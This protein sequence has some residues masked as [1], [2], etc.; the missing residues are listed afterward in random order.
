MIK[1]ITARELHLLLH[2]NLRSRPDIGLRNA[3]ADRVLEPANP[4]EP[5]AVQPPRRW[6]VL[7]CVLS[8]L[9]IGLFVYFNALATGQDRIEPEQLDRFEL[10]AGH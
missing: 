1:E 3:V 6:F 4:F 8:L 9:T 5:Q 10:E 2:R 7:F